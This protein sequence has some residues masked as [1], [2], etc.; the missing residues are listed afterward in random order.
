MADT[1]PPILLRPSTDTQILQTSFDQLG[2]ESDRGGTR[3][4]RSRKRQ[5]VSL[6]AEQNREVGRDR[7]GHGS[8][9]GCPTKFHGLIVKHT[10]LSVNILSVAD[11]PHHDTDA[12]GLE[13]TWL[14]AGIY[15]GLLSGMGREL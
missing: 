15:Q 10:A 3:R 11:V 7:V 1:L 12:A 5:G 8:L 13:R 6:C 14:Q 9:H 4:T 2:G